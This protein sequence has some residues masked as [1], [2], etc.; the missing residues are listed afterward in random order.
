MALVNETKTSAP[1]KTSLLKEFSPKLLKV[2][3][4][5]P[6]G[7]RSDLSA[8]TAISIPLDRKLMKRQTSFLHRLSDVLKDHVDYDDILGYFTITFE[9]FRRHYQVSTFYNP[10]SLLELFLQN[11]LNNSSVGTSVIGIEGLSA[12]K[13]YD[14]DT[15][16][17]ITY[18]TRLANR[19]MHIGAFKSQNY[20]KI[21][22]NSV[23]GLIDVI[24][25]ETGTHKLI[26]ENG[27]VVDI[28]MLFNTRCSMNEEGLTFPTAYGET[29]I[30]FD[31]ELELTMGSLRTLSDNRLVKDFVELLK[32]G[33]VEK[34]VV[35]GRY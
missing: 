19:L 24:S 8:E 21:P 22:Y 5:N 25:N 17:I 18:D 3:L 4:L 29:C 16:K 34:T 26:I 11:I 7:E 23:D 1:P 6:I 27:E 35:S 14:I 20:Y 28:E 15:G 10:I 33:L 2:V 30:K 13:L 12:F 32:Y 31:D 9:D